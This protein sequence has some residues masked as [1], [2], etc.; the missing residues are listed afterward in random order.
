MFGQSVPLGPQWWVSF[1]PS[2]L[3][4]YLRSPVPP[5]PLHQ[6]L[7]VSLALGNR[8][9]Q[10]KAVSVQ[11]RFFPGPHTLVLGPGVG[12]PKPNP[13][14]WVGGRSDT[15]LPCVST[16]EKKSFFRGLHG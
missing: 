13:I 8:L 6:V 5:S 7:R 10:N 9:R 15:Q 2:A 12:H 16:C 14:Q 11:A 4:S 1:V 3:L